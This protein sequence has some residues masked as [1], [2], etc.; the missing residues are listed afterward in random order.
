MKVYLSDDAD[1]DLLVIH[2]YLA[3]RNPAAALSLAREF[4]ATFVRLS[5]FPFIGRDRS[6]LMSGVRSLVLGNY[7]VFY[8][9]EADRV[10][11]LRIMDGRRDIDS[12]F[13]R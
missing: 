13:Q 11:V 3:E 4:Q 9:L 12:E 6:H 7:V 8:R 5:R 1:A 2:S 10:T